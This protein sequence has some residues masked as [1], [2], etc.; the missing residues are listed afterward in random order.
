MVVDDGGID[1]E[2]REG[3]GAG[4]ERGRPGKRGNHDRAGF[5]LPPG[6]DDG[7]ASGANLLVI[8]HPGLGIDRF[9]D[10]AEEA[11]RREVVFVDPLVTP[12]DEGADGGWCGVE[13]GHAVILDDAPETI[14]V[15]PVRR[16][17]IHQ[18]SRTIGQRTV[19]Q[20]AVAGDPADV[21]AA[22]IDVVLAEIEN[23]FRRGVGLGE[24][25]GCGV[26]DALGFSGRAA[27]VEN[28]ERVLAVVVDN[29][30]VG[31]DVFQFAMPPD[32]A[33]FLDMDLIVGTA[34]DDH[35]LD[36]RFT[37]QRGIDIVLERN[38]GTAAVATV[39]RD[40]A[41]R[42]AV[43]D[44][45]ADAV[46]TEPAEDDRVHRADPC[47]SQHGDGGFGDEWH[48]DDDPVALFHP[49]AFEDIGKETNF[50]LELSVSEG[51]FFTRFAF[52]DDGGFVFTV[53]HGVAVDAIFRDVD[54]ASVE[55]AGEGDL[56]LQDRFP[57]AAP[58]EFGRLFSPEFLRVFDRGS[59][60]ALVVREVFHPRFFAEFAGRFNHA[61]FD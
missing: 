56:P 17:F 34:E 54:R 35:F 5:G 57:F 20:V 42:A 9:T 28:E 7:T 49:I 47:A 44:A 2:E 31:I 40:H 32:I 60:L 10:R 30:R 19:D 11:E 16:A 21:G 51:A 14:R 6:V 55:P 27:G 4:F 25:T 24:V 13:N 1:A 23:V 18:A 46:R 59:V 33:S 50:A 39:G 52:P 26:E 12:F 15:G 37:G 29:R 41:G 8:P 36:R 43:G 61:V 48:V 45:V 38:D 3:R 58:L 53:A 22:P